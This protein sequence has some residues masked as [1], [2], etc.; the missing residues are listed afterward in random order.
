MLDLTIAEAVTATGAALVCGDG[1]KRLQGVTTDSRT[2]EQGSAFICFA[3]ERVNGNRFAPQAIEAG[4]AAVVLTEDASADLIQLAN[5]HGCALLRAAEVAVEDRW[6]DAEVTDAAATEFVLRLAEAWRERNPQWVVV[7]VTGSVGKTTT[8]DMLSCAL[9]TSF[10]THATKGNFNNLVGLPLTLLAA[11]ADAQVVVAEMGMNH[12]GELTRLSQVAR[13]DVALITNVGTSHIGFLGS[14]ENI[15]RAKAEI[16]AGMK[17]SDDA[18]H[19]VPSCLVVTEDNDFAGMIEEQFCVPAG[20]EMIR[21]G[22]GAAC[23]V[24]ATGI[25]LDDESRPS[26]TLAFGDGWNQ[27]VTLDAPGRHVVSDFLLAMAIV[28]RLGADRA[29]AAEAVAH[30]PATHMRLEVKTAPGKPRVID[31]SY[32]ASPNS[33]AAA[34][35]VLC[36]MS[37]TGRRVAVLG[38]VGELG[39]QAIRLHGYM[40]AYAAGKPLDLLVFVGGENAREMAEAA[41]TMGFSEDRIELFETAQAALDVMGPVLG[42]D[43]LVLAKGSRAVGLDVFAEGVLA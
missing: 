21:V 9:A 32:N 34:L 6:E 25:T 23:T 16:L 14:R 1:T 41:R 38:Q 11:P 2:I 19:A 13:P 40:G 42:E 8:K 30:M 26:F 35:D 18:G 22:T 17:P 28:D 37:C 4:A 31:D 36:A 43:D 12:A 10:A 27:P 24:R 20:V 39:D 29:K 3:G 5:D 33:M 7:G 15:A